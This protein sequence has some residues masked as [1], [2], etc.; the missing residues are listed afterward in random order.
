MIYALRKRHRKMWLLL[1]ILLPIGFIAAVLAVPEMVV[2][3]DFDIKQPV[4]YSDIISS[5][6]EEDYEV[7]LRKDANLPG[8]QV[9][10]VVKEAFKVPTVLVFFSHQ[11]TETIQNTGVLGKIGGPGSHR[12][13]LGNIAN[14]NPQIYLLLYDKFK[15]QVFKKITIENE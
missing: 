15:E 5:F 8:R 9:E 1:G 2:E 14:Q 11:E 4:L 7:H 3:N 12:F 13:N 6:E 10:F